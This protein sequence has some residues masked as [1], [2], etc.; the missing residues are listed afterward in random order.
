MTYVIARQIPV[1]T[2]KAVYDYEVLLY[3]EIDFIGVSNLYRNNNIP[4]KHFK[5]REK[6]ANYLKY[7]A[8]NKHTSP[9]CVFNKRYDGTTSYVL[10]ES[11][12]DTRLASLYSTTHRLVKGSVIIDF[13]TNPY[14]EG[15]SEVTAHIKSIGGKSTFVS[16]STVEAKNFQCEMIKVGFSS[17]PCLPEETLPFAF[18]LEQ[19][20]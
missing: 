14:I 9:V 6:A 13:F 8:P 2:D 17:I 20:F 12:P 18:D 11:I 5:S 3:N 4:I 15:I 1:D 19:P 16:Y 10:L 7:V